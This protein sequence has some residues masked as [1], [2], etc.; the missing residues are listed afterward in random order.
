MVL[1]SGY[2]L[3]VDLIP[4]FSQFYWPATTLDSALYARDEPLQ[5]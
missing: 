2:R 3:A 1:F 4:T 5:Q